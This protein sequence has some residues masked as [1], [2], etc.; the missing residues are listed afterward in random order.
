MAKRILLILFLIICMTNYAFATTQNNVAGSVQSGLNGGQSGVGGS[1]GGVS[2]KAN[3]NYSAEVKAIIQAYNGKP[4]SVFGNV[5]AEMHKKLNDEGLYM[6]SSAKDTKISILTYDEL[7]N[8]CKDKM[9]DSNLEVGVG[10]SAQGGSIIAEIQAKLNNKAKEAQTDAY[11]AMVVAN[12]NGTSPYMNS[13]GKGT[14]CVKEGYIV[15]DQA[16]ID[17]MNSLPQEQRVAY[18]AVE[19]QTFLMNNPQAKAIKMDLNVDIHNYGPGTYRLDTGEPFW[20]D[21]N[22]DAT[23]VNM[24]GVVQYAHINKSLP[25]L[26]DRCGGTELAFRGW[27]DHPQVG[28]IDDILKDVTEKGFSLE[29]RITDLIDKTAR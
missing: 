27:I 1:G 17:Y 18:K 22:K 4:Q 3:G 29:S 26:S 2:N 5:S 25:E 20:I 12:P 19:I 7:Y 28:A 24:F 10:Y 16:G 21:R 15:Q 13:L 8:Y 14:Y 6:V 23:T 11:K 9:N